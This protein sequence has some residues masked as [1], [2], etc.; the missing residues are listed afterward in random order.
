V[1]NDNAENEGYSAEASQ[2]NLFP[3]QGWKRR[4]PEILIKPI[5]TP[6]VETAVSRGGNDGFLK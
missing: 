5:S 6:G 1:K 2:P 3:P 4:F